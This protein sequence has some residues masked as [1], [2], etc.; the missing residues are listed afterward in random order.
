MGFQSTVR[1]D[2]TTGIIGEF[3]EG[4]PIRAFR[5]ILNST[6]A[7]NNVF[8]RAFTLTGNSDD[9]V[10]AGGTGAFAGI[11]SSPKEHALLGTSA[12]TLEGS[13]QLPNNVGATFADMGILYINLENA[14][15]EGDNIEYD[16]GSATA[17]DAGK[18]YSRARAESAPSGAN[19]RFV[20]N[21]RLVRN[22][23]PAAGLAVI[24]L[25]N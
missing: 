14:G 1:A 9:T 20:P 22:N 13:L 19:R 24:Q 11:M 15:N 8:G 4:G 25:T 21:C 12:G 18:L 16:T 17:A 2:Q 5:K 7:T 6:A 23:I 10:A 3:A